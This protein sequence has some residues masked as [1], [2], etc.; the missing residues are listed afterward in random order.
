MKEKIIPSGS[1]FKLI[2][3]NI[4]IF[5]KENNKKKEGGKDSIKA[6]KNI[7]LNSL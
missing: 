1:N 4:G 2:L 5:A 6:F 7:Q 3:P